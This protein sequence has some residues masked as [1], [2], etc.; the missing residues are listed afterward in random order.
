MSEIQE[1]DANL[2]EIARLRAQLDTA[3]ADALA[4]RKGIWHFMNTLREAHNGTHI[5]RTT[6]ES[7]VAL[8]RLWAAEHP[9]AALLAELTVL[10]ELAADVDRWRESSDARDL[11]YVLET[12]DKIEQMKGNDQ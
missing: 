12:M 1:A 5:H 7:V 11:H 10:R 4:L 2:A 9:G 6:E 8:R 3:E